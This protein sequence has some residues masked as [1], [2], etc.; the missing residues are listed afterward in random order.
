MLFVALSMPVCGAT[1]SLHNRLT[2]T[3][4]V[5]FIDAE[6][7]Q[8]T[9]FVT[10][11]KESLLIDTGWA[12]YSGRD[13]DRIVQAARLAGVSKLDYVLITHYHEDHV[14]GAAQLVERFPVG[15]FI[16][17]G[18]NRESDDANTV[19]S[20][21]AYQSII[22]GPVKH[23]V[24]N[25]GDRLPLRG[26]HAIIVSA[27]GKVIHR[28]TASHMSPNRYCGESPNL[29][30]DHTENA[31]SVG[32]LLTFGKIRLLDLGD[33]TADRERELMCPENP[34][35]KVDVWIVSHHGFEQSNSPLLV[36]SIA[37][38]IAI[39]ENGATK[40]GSASVVDTLLASPSLE[41]LWQLHYSEEGGF[42]HNT[43]GPFIANLPGA[44]VGNYLKLEAS[45]DGSLD[46]VNSRTDVSRHYD[47]R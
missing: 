41:T 21:E 40:G 28:R 29:A 46:I 37:P 8:A 18:E 17:H 32:V 15:T 6:G 2:R 36:Y 10:P 45:S 43:G 24:V 14:G 23:I 9:L 4:Q 33:L 31:R 27:D 39:M 42:A 20:W 30:A 3:L 34:L 26:I 25:A 19:R 44:D 11:S 47:P 5:Y 1:D 7:G 16:D 13:A 38:R 22:A 35:G 12:D